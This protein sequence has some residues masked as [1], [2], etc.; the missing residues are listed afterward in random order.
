MTH[1]NKNHKITFLYVSLINEET[2]F[3]RLR[4]YHT[5]WAVTTKSVISN[6]LEN[7]VESSQN[8]SQYIQNSFLLVL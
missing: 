2:S 5:F 8:A 7:E 3:V 1:S 4:K 6:V